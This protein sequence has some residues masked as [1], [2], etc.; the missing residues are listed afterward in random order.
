MAEDIR[1]GSG[2]ASALLLLCLNKYADKEQREPIRKHLT[3]DRLQDDQLRLHYLY[4][5]F[6]RNELDPVLARAARHLDTPDISLM[7]RLCQD[8][9]D[10]RLSKHGKCCDTC[11]PKKKGGVR[12]IR[13]R[14]L[15]FLQA[16]LR[17]SGKEQDN[18]KWLKS[19]MAPKVFSEIKDQ[20][21][22]R[23]LNTEYTLLTH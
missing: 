6:C 7:M 5:F 2:Y 21:I 1:L 4:V 15:P 22:Q 11:L 14:R 18:I 9:K 8:A 19:V 23:F 16:L 3:L 12:T 20:A 13:A 10:D 17:A